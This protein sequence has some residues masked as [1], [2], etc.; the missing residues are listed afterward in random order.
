MSEGVRLYWA[1]IPGAV[2]YDVI[3]A[4]LSQLSVDAGRLLLGRVR[5]LARA[6][7]ETALSEGSEGSIP[8]VGSA[9]LYFVQ[10]RTEQGGL[11]YGTESAPWPRLPADC[12]GGCP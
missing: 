11:G 10:A 9:I 3:A 8:P 1:E 2:A 12:A 7:R 4:E 6:S 5:V